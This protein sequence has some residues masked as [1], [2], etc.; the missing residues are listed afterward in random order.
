MSYSEK[1]RATQLVL[2]HAQ[3]LA[4]ALAPEGD[5]GVVLDEQ[6][7]GRPRPSAT[8]AWTARCTSHASR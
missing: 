7:R 2:G 6:Q 1:P 5:D 8:S 4:A 3:V